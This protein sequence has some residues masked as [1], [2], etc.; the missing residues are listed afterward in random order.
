MKKKSIYK[1]VLVPALLLSLQSCFVAK[2]Y[3]SPQVVEAEY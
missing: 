3:S 2:E 1:F